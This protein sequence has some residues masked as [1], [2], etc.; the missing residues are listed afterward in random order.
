MFDSC[1]KWT[2]SCSI[3][4]IRLS[5][6]QVN[7]LC[8]KSAPKLHNKLC[9]VSSR[10]T[11]FTSPERG[12]YW[13]RNYDKETQLI[14]SLNNGVCE[15]NLEV[16]GWRYLSAIQ[17]SRYHHK[18]CPPLVSWPDDVI[19][20]KGD[21]TW[22]GH[23]TI[24]AHSAF[25]CWLYHKRTRATRLGAGCPVTRQFDTT[26]ESLCWV[27]MELLLREVTWRCGA[28]SWKTFIRVCRVVLVVVNGLV[29]PMLWLSLDSSFSVY[30]VLV[31]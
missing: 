26:K 7:Q 25:L 8:F 3:I 31:L 21:V 10:G 27:W 6:N 4:T 9:K 19:E 29:F 18:Q 1:S 14:E 22:F 17:V 24:G 20:W 23:V 30:L 5:I 13:Y 15:R 2:E 11:C 16:S 12:K 28:L